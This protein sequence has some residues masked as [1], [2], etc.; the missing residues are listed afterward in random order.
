MTTS[1]SWY[2]TW[3]TAFRNIE[4]DY[5]QTVPRQYPLGVYREGTDERRDLDA[6]AVVLSW[7]AQGSEW[8]QRRIFPQLDSSAMFLHLWEECFSIVAGATTAARQQAA[9]AYCRLM[10]GTATK[11]TIQ[12]IMAPAFGASVDYDEVGFSFASFA[13]VA[14]TTFTDEWARAYALT[15]LHI[16][17]IPETADPDIS[18][19]LD[20]IA[21]WRPTWL[22]VSVGRYETLVWGVGKWGQAAWGRVP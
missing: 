5:L 18:V 4:E 7:I 16:Y 17:H 9:I 1:P 2:P 11:E 8:I 13:D 12:K 3:P 19:A 6:V 15:R 22:H 20:L 10:L 14:A 21:R